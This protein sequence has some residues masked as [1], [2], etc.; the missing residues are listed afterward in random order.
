MKKL[1][2]ILIS[3]FFLQDI[4][5]QE[6]YIWY[7]GNKINLQTILSKRFVLVNN[8]SDTIV[9]KN[10]IINNGYIAES[11]KGFQINTV[12]PF[13]STN[14]DEKYWTI[15]ETNNYSINLSDS[16][17]LYSTPFFLTQD[18][19]LIALSHLFYVKLKTSEDI[20][21][22]ENMATANNVTILG[23]YK[24]LPL[25]YT[26]SCSKE[27][28]GNALEMANS[29]YESGL[30]EFTDPDFF[31]NN[32]SHSNGTYSSDQWGLF[33]F[34]QYGG[35]SGI[36]INYLSARQITK[37]NSDIIVAVLDGGVEF[38]HPDLTNMY[39]IS[40]DAESDDSPSR[41]YDAHGTACAGIIGANADN[42]IGIDGIAP[43]CPIMSISCK[44]N[45]NLTSPGGVGKL[46]NAYGFAIDNNVSVINNSWGFYTA[47]AANQSL[48]YAINNALTEGRNGKGAVLVFA[49]GNNNYSIV[50][51][52][53]SLSGVITVG[54]ISPCGERKSFTSCDTETTWGSNYGQGLDIVAP[55]VLIST[56]DRQGEI[57]YNS[58]FDY[59]NITEG[60]LISYDYTDNDYTVYFGGTSAACPHVAGVAAL[61]LSV[62]PNLTS[63]EVKD[64][65]ESTAQ[66]IRGIQEPDGLYDYANSPNRPNG[67]WNEEMGYGLVDA[68]AAV[69]R[70]ACFNEED[71]VLE[72]NVNYDITISNNY[73][74]SGTITIKSG[75]SLTINNS[76]LHMSPGAK[77][78]VEPGAK[79][80][81]NGGTITS[82][83]PD[84][85]WG[86][87]FVMG[88][89]NQPQTQQHQGYVELNN[90]TIENAKNAISTWYPDNWNTTGGIIKAANTIFRNNLRSVEYLSYNNSNQG[91]FTN[92]NFSWDE[93]LFAHDKSQLS[94]VTMYEVTGVRFTKCYFSKENNEADT[95][96]THGILS[97]N[98]G[99]RVT[100]RFTQDANMPI[101]K[102]EFNYLDYG[103]RASNLSNKIFD[104]S[105]TIFNFNSCGVFSSSNRNFSVTESNFNIRPKINPY[106]AQDGEEIEKVSVG[107]FSD[108][109]SGYTIKKNDFNG[110]SFSSQSFP[111]TNT[112]GIGIRNSGGDANMINNNTFTNLYGGS[113]ALGT[114]R[115]DND[116]I[117]T[118]LQ[119]SCNTFS[120]SLYGLYVTKFDANNPNIYG[121]CEEQ[122]SL[123]IPA[124]N[125]FYD[126]ITADICNSN[127]PNINYYFTSNIL[128]TGLTLCND[129]VQL[130]DIAPK[131]NTCG[132]I[133][134]AKTKDEWYYDRD[135]LRE[136]YAILLFN[137]NNLLDG[138]QKDELLDKLQEGW[139][140]DV[141][142]VRDEYLGASPYLSVEVLREMV[143][144]EKLP[145]AVCTEILL[146]NPEATQKDEFKAFMY[147]G[148]N[149]L[150]SLSISLIE[151]SW[152]EKTFRANME[153]NISAKLTELEM[154]SRSLIVII[155]TDSLGVNI[156]EYRSVL[157]EMKSPATRFEL[158][159]SY[160]GKQEYPQ[161]R[162]SLSSLLGNKNYTD[163]VERY[164]EYIDLVEEVGNAHY[165][166]EETLLYLS[167]YN[168]AIGSKAKSILYFKGISTDYHPIVVNMENEPK[169][170]LVRTQGSLSDL[171]NADITVVPNPAKDHI[172]L[173]YNLPPR[174]IYTIKIYDNKGIEL[175]TKTLKN[176]KGVQTIELKNLKSGAYYYTITDSKSVIKSDK[177][178]IVK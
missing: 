22:L 21:L 14:P 96:L 41:I 121:I 115:S 110:I 27:S 166:S 55:G 175:L 53:S 177:I 164:L 171:S 3:I 89:R 79:L 178:I 114:N 173:T 25:L 127:C 108:I 159:D 151:E 75:Y 16:N 130:I 117:I 13:K 11:F 101:E 43:N 61:M 48:N 37:G 165:L 106:I 119:Y 104:V 100:G 30:F 24:H 152:E 83:C 12:I 141:W 72:K 126:N 143:Q 36:D 49:S 47:S 136:Q 34:G 148:E 2:M 80:I 4:L 172:I 123:N 70:A 6:T 59:N 66:K 60:T 17:I 42:S 149:Y 28:Q 111:P 139:D 93:N 45:M 153:S 163:Q 150:T 84:E 7:N 73:F 124:L 10:Q 35:E 74:S 137:Y 105:N 167:E 78:I 133:G 38:G 135:V 168:D 57:G 26:L 128:N 62:N 54:A 138:G 64:I 134:T 162:E 46:I 5:A 103:I 95:I 169:N 125:F 81:V 120:N 18:S 97:E 8:A 29:F 50:D 109:S 146:S 160:I 132:T 58:E 94:H 155:L 102:S 86:A 157:S 87:I 158:A 9:L 31:G 145:L 65:I 112:L 51:Y 71:L 52:P 147:K 32:L 176:N 40:Y 131:E 107:I 92:C 142:A 23:N 174:Q 39:P 140:G 122:I 118:G 91:L 63:Q 67:T 113:Q 90:A 44:I 170:K 85:F 156:N 77:I 88:D 20:N 69:K 116:I 98:A 154:A 82:S 144:S 76:T 19:V 56:T 33:N 68:Y 161:A 129:N 1:L 15:V 99:F